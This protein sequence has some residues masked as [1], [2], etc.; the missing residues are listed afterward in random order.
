MERG[1]ETVSAQRARS[2]KDARMVSGYAARAAR[3]AYLYLSGCGGADWAASL[4]SP[5]HDGRLP[6]LT[7]HR[8]RALVK[9]LQIRMGMRR[10]TRLTNAHS[11]KIENHRHTLALYFTYYNF[12]RIHS[13]LLHS[14]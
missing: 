7:P 11:K 9:Y 1:E 13:T 5:H 12:A 6:I 3:P 14:A 8:I 10:F 4:Q 2:G